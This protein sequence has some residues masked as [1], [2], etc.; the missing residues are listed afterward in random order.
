MHVL[1]PFA[2][3]RS[4]GCRA[5]M[6]EASWPVLT[7]LL[8]RLPEVDRDRGE[9]TSFSAPHERV[10]A[11]ALGWPVADGLLPWAAR[12]AA[13]AGIAVGDAAWGLVSPV[14]WRV[15]ADRV[16]LFDPES[17][18]LT[19]AESRAFFAAVQPLFT[20]EGWR[21]EYAAAHAWYASHP[22]LTALPT[23]SLDR[24]IGRNVDAWLGDAAGPA[25]IVRRLQAEVQMLLHTHA[26]NERREERG[27]PSVNSFWLSGCGAA[28]PALATAAEPQI[29]L[30]LRGPALAEDWQAWRAAWQRLEEGLIAGLLVAQQRGN[31]IVLTLA[32][33]KAAVTFAAAPSSFVQRLKMMWNRPA[34]RTLL[35]SL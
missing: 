22:T 16:D 6:G 5:A 26:V 18:E 24:V 1:I 33:E 3:A 31:E 32:G 4:E 11:R 13:R 7:Q 20:D 28:R 34:M 27:L 25:R 8:A 23:A 10:L 21:L 14:H 30:D 15:G 2:A 9:E 19:E 17:L 35:E 29:A 12:D